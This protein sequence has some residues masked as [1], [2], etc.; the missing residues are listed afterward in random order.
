MCSKNIPGEYTRCIYMC[1]Y[2]FYY[3][4]YYSTSYV[5]YCCA[6]GVKMLL[7]ATHFF[8]QPKTSIEVLVISRDRPLSQEVAGT[9]PYISWKMQGA[10]DQMALPRMDL[11][12]FFLQC[13]RADIQRKP[14]RMKQHGQNFSGWVLENLYNVYMSVISAVSKTRY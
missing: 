5:I 3:C 2:F 12:T 13:L 7:Y 9:W 8:P 14:G 1:A 10:W 11:S 4:I 6:F